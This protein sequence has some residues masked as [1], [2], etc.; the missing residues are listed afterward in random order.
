MGAS[1]GLSHLLVLSAVVAVQ[2]YLIYQAWRTA[3]GLDRQ[4]WQAIQARCLADLEQRAVRGM[5]PDWLFYRDEIDRGYEPLDDRI[6]RCA[7]AALAVGL[8][9]TLLAIV[10]HLLLE[11]GVGTGGLDASRLIASAGAS[12]LG[13][14]L[15]VVSHLTIV[16]VLLPRAERKFHATANQM[17]IELRRTS[18]STAPPEG[19]ART[20][21][22]ELR[23]IRQAVSHQFSE[24]FAQSV[25]GFPQ[26]VEGLRVQ[27]ERLAEVVQAQGE[28]LGPAAAEL[29][30][31]A[32]AVEEAGKRLKPGAEG[33]TRTATLLS[34]LP[35]RLGA[36]LD[37]RRDMWLAAIRDEQKERLNELMAVH[38]KAVEGASERERLMLERARELLGA[39][40]EVSITAAKIP[41]QFSTQIERVAS[42]LGAEFGKEARQH[43]ADAADQVQRAYIQLAEKVAHHEQE[44]R[45]NLTAVISELLH[46]IENQVRTGVAGELTGAAQSLRAVAAEL[47][48]A[49]EV[50]RQGVDRWESLQT[51]ALRGWHEAGGLIFK[52]SETLANAEGPLRSSLSALA[53]GG[54]HLQKALRDTGDLSSQAVKALSTATARYLEQLQP[55]QRSANELLQQARASQQRAEQVLVR[56]GE[57]I[58]LLLTQRDKEHVQGGRA[59]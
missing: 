8:G 50:L 35:E 22:V 45:N 38:S 46:G 3:H 26:V 52:A 41:D 23:H 34:E 10:S 39:V 58:R 51:E 31:C 37:D 4:A 57:L 40:S 27:V 19:L 29:A 2:V 43:S 36:V 21:Q 13:S 7:S 12:L 47:P 33:L 14:L 11:G 59:S 5:P 53:A 32:R 56:Q 28:G 25:T 16:L 30:T 55:V 17:L 24:V 1:F 42:R 18:D 54:D 44:W 49:S 9:G 20:L 48:A 6:R 15:G